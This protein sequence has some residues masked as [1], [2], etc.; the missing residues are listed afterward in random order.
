LALRVRLESLT[1]GNFVVL[2]ERHLN[3]I[4]RE[5]TAYY[6]AERPHQSLENLPPMRG[7]PTDSTEPVEIA[8]EERLGGLLKHYVRRAA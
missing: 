3:H 5:F 2:G 8:C 6:H 1:Y 4:V 7:A